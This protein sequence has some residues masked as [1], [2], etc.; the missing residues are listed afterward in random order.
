MKKLDYGIHEKGNFITRS[1]I[2]L[3]RENL[4]MFR[5]SCVVLSTY[6]HV[7]QDRHQSSTS[8]IQHGAF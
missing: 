2:V 8:P 3:T 5:N 1:G 7:L 6:L 4:V